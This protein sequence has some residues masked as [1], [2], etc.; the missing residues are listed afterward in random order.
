VHHLTKIMCKPI[1]LL[2]VYYEFGTD[3]S[4]S[5]RRLRYC[6]IINYPV[7][8]CTGYFYSFCLPSF[9][10]GS[11]SLQPYSRKKEIFTVQSYVYQTGPAM[12]YRLTTGDKK[13]SFLQVDNARMSRNLQA[14]SEKP[15]TAEKMGF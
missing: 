10:P 1:Q 11:Y 13:L 9:F 7:Y 15:N 6:L 12:F 3:G 8:S 14:V 5:G 2:S 4:R